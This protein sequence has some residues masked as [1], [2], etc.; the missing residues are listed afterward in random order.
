MCVCV[1]V[2]VE[3]R[4]MLEYGPRVRLYMYTYTYTFTQE[5]SSPHIP[6]SSP[7]C[8]YKITTHVGHTCMYVHT[9]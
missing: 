8:T 6:S 5:P 7:P 2:Y 4:L 1:C 3:I 9:Q